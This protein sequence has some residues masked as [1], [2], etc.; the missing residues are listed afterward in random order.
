MA[1]RFIEE[2]INRRS[3]L[4][5]SIHRRVDLLQGRFIAG[6]IHRRVDSWQGRFIAGS[7][8]CRVNS[9]QGGFIAELRQLKT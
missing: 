5:G 1:G 9:L 8:H 4:R 3:I 6:T 2:S 7:V